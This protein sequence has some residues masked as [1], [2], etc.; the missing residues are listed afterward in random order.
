MKPDR[1]V[2]EHERIGVL[3]AR[4]SPLLSAVARQG[5]AEHG[6]GAVLYCE[7]LEATLLQA[8]PFYLPASEPEFAK[9]GTDIE[10]AVASYRPLSDGVV[11][12]VTQEDEVYVVRLRLPSSEKQA[13]GSGVH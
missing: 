9:M 10:R 12:V 6:R 1:K 4:K 3:V 13:L 11:V 5:Y 7:A 8:I 2:G